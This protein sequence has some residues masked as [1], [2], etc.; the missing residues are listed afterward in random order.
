MSGGV[1]IS[2]A[3][4][5]LLKIFKT[6]VECGGFAA[7]Q[8]EL[9]VGQSTISSHMAALETRLGVRLCERGRAGFRLTEEGRHIYESAQRLFRSVE[10]FRA[11]VEGLR[12]RLAGEL[13]VGTIDNVITNP[14]FPLS[15]AIGL[16]KQ[17]GGNVRI[18]IQIGRPAEIE[19]AV[20]DGSLHV[21]IGGYTR[22]I[23]GIS[24][25]PILKETQRLY[26]GADHPLFP[27]PER[28]IDTAALS[29]CQY[30]KRPYVPDVDIPDSG[31]LNATAMA[32]NME[33]IAFLVLSGQFIGFLPEHYAEP[34]VARGKLR[35]LMPERMHYQSCHELLYRVS[36]PPPLAV[37]CF[38]SD[39]LDAFRRRGNVLAEPEPVST[40]SR[41]K[42]SR[43]PRLREAVAPGE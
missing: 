2:Q 9:N 28:S 21:G 5:R 12:G 10:S 7:A 3:D 11:D 1:N 4:I 39:L 26:C 35:T 42:A 41:R 37:R 38:V 29:R 25:I 15:E 33:A 34:F 43:A 8:I 31:F 14:G 18:H 19:R 13:Y 27:V 30:V 23:S 22:R 17:R 6:V 16:F 36:T 40:R 20:V 24:H 32:E